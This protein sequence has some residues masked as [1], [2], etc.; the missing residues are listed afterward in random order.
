MSPVKIA[1]IQTG[2]WGD[3]INSTLMFK[4]LRNHYP[5]C[6]INVYT[7]NLYKDAFTNNP[8]VNS[9]CAT[10]T[11]NKSAAIGLLTETLQKRTTYWKSQNYTHVFSP[12]PFHNPDSRHS[13][14]RPELGDNLIYSWVHALEKEGIQCSL[15]PQTSLKLTDTEVDKVDKYWN[16]LPNLEDKTNILMECDSE[17][18]QTF[19]T[20]T[21]TYQV[22][23]QILKNPKVNLFISR[24]LEQVILMNRLKEIA[25]QRVHF[26][27][28]LSLR[29]CAELF[30]RC[31][32]FMGVSSGLTN[33]CNTDWCKKDITWIETINNFSVCSAP[34]RTT[35]KIFWFQNNLPRFLTM[36]SNTL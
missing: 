9:I 19:W 36:I 15:P 6:I 28:G 5:D 27:G 35:G 11:P 10:S 30:N 3:N 1:L 13:L 16:S 12:H 29:E 4:P 18:G 2:G 26:V 33:F 24:K 31:Q 7:S 8:Y 21:W 23:E 22:G 32:V 20:D 34:I 14:K 25:P 17:S